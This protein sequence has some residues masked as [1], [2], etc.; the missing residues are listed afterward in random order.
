M[1]K[2]IKAAIPSRSVLN[3]QNYDYSDCYDAE[4]VELKNTITINDVTKAFFSSAPKQVH[5][6]FELRNKIVSLFGLKTPS[7]VN[8]RQEILNNSKFEV[9]NRFGLFTVFQKTENEIILGEN[10]KHLD[11][12]ISLSLQKPIENSDSNKKVTIVTTVFYHNWFGR[13]YFLPVKP[14]HKLIVPAMLKGII[15]NLEN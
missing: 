14:I 10:D 12:R 3:H 11:F 8:N 1:M 5:F 7:K 4:L 2:I 9:G 6:L 13:L 15:K